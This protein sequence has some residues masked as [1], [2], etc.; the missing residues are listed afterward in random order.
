MRGVAN[1]EKNANVQ[2]ESTKAV[3]GIVMPLSPMDNCDA[4]H[5]AEVR[6]IIEESIEEAGFEANLVSDADDVG[7]IHKR[8]IQN[9]YENPIVV[10]DVSAKNPNVMFE[11]GMR[12]AFDK[13]TIIIKDDQT[14]Y[15]FDTAQIEHLGYPRDLRH[16]QIVAFKEKL[17]DKIRATYEKAT[18]DKSYTT[19]LKN[20][21]AFKIAKLDEKEVSG[22]EFIVEQLQ[23]IAAS[24]QRL[25]LSSQP[26]SP[27][28]P[29]HTRPPFATG[30]VNACMIGNK[31]E[32][33]AKFL[34]Q[35]SGR[36]GVSKAFIEHRSGAHKHLIVDLEDPSSP[37][38]DDIVS[39]LIPSAR[40]IV[41]K[42]GGRTIQIKR[43]QH[44][45]KKS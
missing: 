30:H 23:T 20:F 39:L 9:L 13:P 10:C 26:L 1:G 38:V 33:I 32:Q 12:L 5:W 6:E 42:T 31:E 15:V 14:T 4:A 44:S 22:Q 43:T 19:F 40:N 16:S 35:I 29:S 8:I 25:Q 28:T 11:F 17:A 41:R 36:P 34:E 2:T 24:I 7:V 21:G 3:C 45:S 27:P 37:A 18:T